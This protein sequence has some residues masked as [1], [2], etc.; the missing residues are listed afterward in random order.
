M[1]PMGPSLSDDAWR[2]LWDGRLLLN[3]VNPYHVVPADPSIASLRDTL[4]VLQGYP[5]THTIYPPGAQLL[6][7]ASVAPAVSF[8][9]DHRVSLVLYKLILIVAEVIGIVCLLALRRLRGVSFTPVILYA[10]HPL[11]IVELAGQGHTD[12]LWVMA[13]G[14][15]FYAYA[16][17]GGGIPALALG[18]ALRMYPLALIPL[19]IPFVG[20]RAWWRGIG[21]STPIL[22]LML[23]FLDPIARDTILTVL[24]RFTN[25]YE[26]NGGVYYGA[27]HVLDTLGVVGSNRVAGALCVAANVVVHGAVLWRCRR[28]GDVDRLMAAALVLVTAQIAFGAKAHIWYFAAPLFIATTLDDGALRRGWLWMSWIAPATYAMYL[29]TPPTERMDVVAVEWLGFVVF[30]VGQWWRSRVRERNGAPGR[31]PR[32][33]SA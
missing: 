21:L 3:G 2:Y 25:Y 12:A 23:V 10:W 16:R 29:V 4:Y 11:P 28:G 15:A 8:D 13:L 17:R 30:A 27:K 14:L 20:W 24:S 9:L 1:L 33:P 31:G 32:Q 7:A 19:W 26:F 18:G 6:F 22:L 5:T